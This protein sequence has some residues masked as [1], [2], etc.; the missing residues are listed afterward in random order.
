[1]TTEFFDSKVRRIALMRVDQYRRNAGAAEHCGGGRTGQSP[2]D[3]GN[4]GVPHGANLCRRRQIDASTGK[5]ALARVIK[6]HFARI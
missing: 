2:A 4:V 6:V 5:K 3:N 1:M